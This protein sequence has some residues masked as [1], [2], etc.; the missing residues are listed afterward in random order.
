[1]NFVNELNALN[2]SVLLC[3]KGFGKNATNNLLDSADDAKELIYEAIE[4]KDLHEVGRLLRKRASSA[5]MIILFR[6][7]RG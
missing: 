4:N 6:R 1:M 2:L 3:C 7:M 5:K